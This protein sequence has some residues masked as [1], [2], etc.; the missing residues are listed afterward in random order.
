MKEP[1]PCPRWADW[2]DAPLP[3]TIDNEPNSESLPGQVTETAD[4][5][6]GREAQAPEGTSGA[7]PA[8]AA[9]RALDPANACERQTQTPR[10]APSERKRP[11][12]IIDLAE[13]RSAMDQRAEAA[14]SAEVKEARE[15]VLAR[16]GAGLVPCRCG[17]RGPGA[18]SGLVP[19]WF[20]KDCIE[21]A[22]P[23][24][25]SK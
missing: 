16:Q 11:A 5:G 14:R 15:R 23:L 12:K 21:A 9:M 19:A 4:T 1:G 22:C 10:P 7:A 24:K 18:G 3:E 20:G 17:A 6:G 25:V 13:A 8:A 2:P